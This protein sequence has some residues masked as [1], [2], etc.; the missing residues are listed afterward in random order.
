MII[1]F[2]FPLYLRPL[3]CCFEMQKSLRME[4]CKKSFNATFPLLKKY[5]KIIKSVLTISKASNKVRRI[6]TS[7]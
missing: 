6:E 1:L 7:A 2:I 5:Y 3:S 4:L